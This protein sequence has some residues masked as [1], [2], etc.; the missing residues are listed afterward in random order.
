MSQDLVAEIGSQDQ[1]YVKKN[2]LHPAF[3]NIWLLLNMKLYTGK[4]IYCSSICAETLK[5]SPILCLI[6]ISIHAQFIAYKFA[7]K[8]T[9]IFNQS[10]LS[11]R[12]HYVYFILCTLLSSHYWWVVRGRSSSWKSEESF[13]FDFM[14]ESIQAIQIHGIDSGNLTSASSWVHL[15]LGHLRLVWL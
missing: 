12:L 1:K 8:T 9:L 5:S 3:T 10:T 7:K 11:L 13:F 4:K 2:P 15:K 14:S 6:Y